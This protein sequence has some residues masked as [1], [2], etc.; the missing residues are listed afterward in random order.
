TRLTLPKPAH[1]A[2]LPAEALE[3]R[4]TDLAGQDASRAFDALRRLSASPDQAVTLLRQRLRPTAPAAPQRMA[5]LL[6][7]LEGERFEVH[8]R[9]ESER[10]RLG[11]SADPGLRKVLDDAP[12]DLRQRVERLLDRLSVP[13]ATPRRELRAVELLELIGNAEARQ[14]LQT[15]TGG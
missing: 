9:A 2:W 6:A 1:A 11:E 10:E 12:L 3:A 4:W 7:D 15:L 14:V 13:T 5:Q 8:R